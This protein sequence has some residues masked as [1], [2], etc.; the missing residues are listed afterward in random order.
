MLGDTVTL[1]TS[2]TLFYAANE[3]IN[4]FENVDVLG[5]P[6]PQFLKD[7]LFNLKEQVNNH[8]AKADGL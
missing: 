3:G 7:S 5:I 8:T 4:I 6:I 1:K 2:V